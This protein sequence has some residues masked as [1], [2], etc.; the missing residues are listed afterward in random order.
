M[1]VA[2]IDS[3]TTVAE[4]CG[5]Q[6]HNMNTLTDAAGTRIFSDDNISYTINDVIRFVVGNN[7]VGMDSSL[8][9]HLINRLSVIAL[10]NVMLEAG[11]L[12]DVWKYQN[13]FDVNAMIENKTKNR[14][15]TIVNGS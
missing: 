8:K 9:L 13:P 7:P 3:L 10:N 1:V 11:Y 6:N 4:V 2:I 14:F 15:L 12:Q 5:L